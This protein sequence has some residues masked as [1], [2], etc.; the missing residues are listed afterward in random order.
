MNLQK[1]RKYLNCRF[2]GTCYLEAH[3]NRVHLPNQS[4]QHCKELYVTGS[5]IRTK[6]GMKLVFQHLKISFVRVS[7]K[8]VDACAAQAKLWLGD[9]VH[10]K[11]LDNCTQ[12]ETN[13]GI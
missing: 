3:D 9:R 4:R 12:Q 13:S 2:P 1:E 10:C 11:M 5:E 6:K 7:E 8:E